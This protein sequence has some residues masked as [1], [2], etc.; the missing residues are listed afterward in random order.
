VST[1][2]LNP[3]PPGYEHAHG[4]NFFFLKG[5]PNTSTLSGLTQ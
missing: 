1:D 3:T 4:L 5:F 2:L